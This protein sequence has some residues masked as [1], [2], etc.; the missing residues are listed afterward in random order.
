MKPIEFPEQ[1]KVYGK[2]Q[3]EYNPLP[4]FHKDTPQDECVSC[5][6]LSF[7][8]RMRILFTGKIW[9]SLMC[10]NKPLTPSLLST[11][12]TDIIDFIESSD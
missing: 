5:W 1:N 10:F 11:K 2:G 12:K 9:L 7:R 3:S 8:E 4:V 6:R